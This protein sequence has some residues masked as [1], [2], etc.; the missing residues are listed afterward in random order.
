[1]WRLS[2]LFQWLAPLPRV[3]KLWSLNPGPAKSF[4]VLQTVR[5]RFNI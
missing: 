2:A 5:H 1:M 4:T 3:Q